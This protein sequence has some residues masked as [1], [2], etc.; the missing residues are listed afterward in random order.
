MVTMT[1]HTQNGI[2]NTERIGR[3][4]KLEGVD[5]LESAVPTLHQTLI[6][7]TPASLR[8]ST[9]PDQ[10]VPLVIAHSDHVLHDKIN[11]RHGHIY[12]QAVNQNTRTV[13]LLNMLFNLLHRPFGRRSTSQNS[14]AIPTRTSEW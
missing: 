3:L 2:I 11:A 4:L 12:Q 1:Q 14:I 6:R 13:R 9:F 5:L 10:I 7:S 8:R